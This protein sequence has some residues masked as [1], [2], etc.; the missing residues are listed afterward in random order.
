MVTEYNPQLMVDPLLDSK[1]PVGVGRELR[2]FLQELVSRCKKFVPRNAG[3]SV[4][5]LN[6]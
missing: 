1:D 6:I 2:E 5:N 4:G 3:T